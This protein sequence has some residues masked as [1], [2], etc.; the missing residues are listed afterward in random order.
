M[1]RSER[2]AVPDAAV[3]AAQAWIASALSVIQPIPMSWA[4]PYR[5]AAR[6]EQGGLIVTVYQD[7][8]L[9][10]FAVRVALR[11]RHA[12]LWPAHETTLHK[13]KEP[14]CTTAIGIPEAL[15]APDDL[16]VIEDALMWAWKGLRTASANQ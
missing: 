4:G 6:I 1:R 15:P 9:P 10:V 5:G 16:I 3:Q 7:T 2:S 13:P 11:S 12:G 14:W 8:E